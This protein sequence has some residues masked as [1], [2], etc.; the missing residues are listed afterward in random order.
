MGI[1]REYHFDLLLVVH[2]GRTLAHVYV[3][4]V[5]HC[6]RTLTHVLCVH[7]CAVWPHLGACLCVCMIVCLCVN[8]WNG[9][10]G[11]PIA[12][13]WLC[14][15]AAL[16]SPML[17]HVYVCMVVHCGRTLT[18]VLCVHGCAVWPHLGACLCVCMVV[19]LCVCMVVCLC[20][21]HGCM[22]VCVH[23]C[24]FVCVHGCM[25]VCVHGCMFVWCA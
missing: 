13:L 1:Y 25:F 12:W 10:L 19:C 16:S 14:I 20:G 5:V 11:A 6:G 21:V 2:Y 7:D 17:T 22:F 4:M 24:M 15:V 8:F 18:H 9:G 3:C 23:G